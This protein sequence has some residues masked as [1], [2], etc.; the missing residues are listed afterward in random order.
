MLT[1]RR[2]LELGAGAGAALSAG[3]A[4]AARRPPDGPGV[5]VNDLHSQLNPTTVARVATPASTEAVQS[6][7]R[8]AA[9]E[10]RAISVMGGNHAMGGQQFGAGTLLL[11]MRGMGRVLGLDADRGLVE[12]EAGIQWPELIRSLIDLQRGRP[13]P[14]SIV[15]KQT[16]ADRLTLGGALAANVHGRG[17]TLRPLVGDVEA[18]TLVG[19]DGAVRR[20]S[21]RENA[22][23]FGLVIG[24]YGLLGVVTAVQLR[25]APRRK[26]RRVVEIIDVD[27]LMPR[28]E[29]RIRAGYLFGD[30]QYA[31]D[32]SSDRLLRRGVF[33]CYAPVPDATPMPA[34]VRELAVSDWQRLLHLSHADKARAFAEYAGYYVTTSGQLYW[35]DTHQL[36]VY[37]DHYHRELDRRLGAAAPGSEMISELYVPRARLPA[38]FDAVRRD[39]RAHGVDV[40]Y[41]TV[42][43]I[44]RDDET[45]L[46]WAR[47]PW[48]CTI[49]NL[50]V[51]HTPAGIERAARDFRRLIDR[52][53]EEGGSYFPTYHRWAE[54][55]QVRAAHPRLVEFLQAKRR[56]DPGER[57]QSDWYRHYRAMLGA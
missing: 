7:V 36:S 47:Q 53:L 32:P 19:P 2:F 4:T 28:L 46:A 1:R 31:T 23:L 10:G 49:F 48:A 40:I 25:L 24:G 15:Q 54:P 8:A 5:A 18:F 45:V 11:D 16:G 57:F 22:E 14:W 12:V 37:I 35:S 50:H 13:A 30:F 21:R 55:A 6:L 39:V 43:L 17:L 29:D 38:F 33:S 44:E 3:C 52:A 42:R 34:E 20:V 56:H 27:D 26:L 9:S 41:G 51:D